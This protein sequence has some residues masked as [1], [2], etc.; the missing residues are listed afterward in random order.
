[1][2]H[3]RVHGGIDPYAL[4]AQGIDPSTVVDFSVNLNPYG[5]CP[6]VIE[7]AREAPLDAYPDPLAR[8]AREAWA[9]VLDLHPDAIAVGHGAASLFWAIA[10]AFVQRGDRVLIA[11]P[12]FSELRV[13][14]EAMGAELLRPRAN[15][16]GIDLEA[17][18][19]PA[20]RARLVYLCS[21]NNPTG[22]R[23]P[24]TE[25]ARFAARVPEALVVLDQSFVA[26]SDH[27]DDAHAR[28]PDNV[29]VVRSLTKEFACPGLRIGLCIA[30]PALVARIEAMRP[31]WATSAPALAAI[32]AAA[33]Q[34]AF[35]A[36]SWL[37][38][39]EDR[40]A[41]AAAFRAI[42]AHVRPSA[43]SF[44]LVCVPIGG[45]AEA[46]CRIF[47]RQRV[48][49]RDCSSF[50]LPAYV[51]VAALPAPQRQRLYAAVE[52]VLDAPRPLDRWRR[53]R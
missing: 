51:R 18:A 1:M 24:P 5:P 3:P 21:P 31:T 20:S 41:V 8:A 36:A 33:G 46:L 40:E 6:A 12:T 11:E 19:K 34:G 32:E 16:H 38:L 30:T 10:R 17:L 37:R 43:T 49:V 2:T 9:R 14:A 26:L 45:G 25:I 22:E 7:A 29:I 39:R 47:M 50:G 52:E 23:L 35:V 28:F 44:Q 13:A 53:P 27:A 48:L 15:D 4:N 42:D